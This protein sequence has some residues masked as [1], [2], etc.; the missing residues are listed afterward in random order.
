MIGRH[1]IRH[2][3]GH[4]NITHTHTHAHTQASHTHTHTHTHARTHTQASYNIESIL[5]INVLISTTVYRVTCGIVF[6]DFEWDF[7]AQGVPVRD[8]D[9][10]KIVARPTIQLNT[11]SGRRK[12]EEG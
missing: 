2:Y 3:Q 7:S 11:P 9:V 8:N 6:A 4:T 1:S 12:E 10:F 5:R